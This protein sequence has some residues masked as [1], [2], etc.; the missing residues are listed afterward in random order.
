[1]TSRWI[2]VIQIQSPLPFQHLLF[3]PPSLLFFEFYSLGKKLQRHLVNYWD[4]E[5]FE[6]QFKQRQKWKNM[7]VWTIWKRGM[8][9]WETW[10]SFSFLR[11]NGS[12]GQ[13]LRRLTILSP[14]RDGWPW[15]PARPGKD[16]HV[17]KFFWKHLI[18]FLITFD[19]VFDN[20]WSS[21]LITCMLV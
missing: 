3:F 1:M 9:P 17:D 11:K 5:F 16:D 18:K 13:F 2:F 19:Q 15:V 8:R 12:K 7:N 21:F 4:W 20:I 6:S 10:R 14:P